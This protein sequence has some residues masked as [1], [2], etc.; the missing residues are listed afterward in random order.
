[1]VKDVVLAR[2]LEHVLGEHLD[3]ACRVDVR[4]ADGSVTLRGH[5]SC[6]LARLLAED[7]AYAMNG[8]KECSNMLVISGGAA[9][10][11]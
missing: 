3:R 4:V 7:L 6:P 10:G 11:S 9:R 2:E 1:M 5:V 8:V